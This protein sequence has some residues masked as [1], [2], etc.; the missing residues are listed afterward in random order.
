MKKLL[1]PAEG[2]KGNPPP[3]LVSNVQVLPNLLA[4]VK[5]KKLLVC[6]QKVKVPFANYRYNLAK[7]AIHFNEITHWR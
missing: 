3:T 4:Q 1:V 2:G 5:Q 6:R 7:L